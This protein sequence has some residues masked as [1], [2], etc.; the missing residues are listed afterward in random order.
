MNTIFKEVNYVN[1]SIR[2]FELKNFIS[3]SGLDKK[4]SEMFERVDLA[5]L[6]KCWTSILYGL[7]ITIV[8]IGDKS[9]Q[10]K[11]ILDN[12]RE[13]DALMTIYGFK[14]REEKLFI[15][16]LDCELALEKSKNC[17]DIEDICDTFKMMEH[18][19][20]IQNSDLDE[21]TKV[22]MIDNLRHINKRLQQFTIIIRSLIV[23]QE[24]R[25]ELESALTQF[26]TDL[27]AYI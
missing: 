25:S 9:D 20:N 21:D 10:N 11:V 1:E 7:P 22:A 8:I 3:C 12:F 26:Y 14:F 27:Y 13:I 15:D 24:E 17:F 5:V 18:I 19:E 16:A 2:A 23:K 4:I 6:E